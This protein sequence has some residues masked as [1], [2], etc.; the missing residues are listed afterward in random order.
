MNL[1]ELFP[2]AA[3]GWVEALELELAKSTIDTPAEIASFCAQLNQESAGL[4]RF[5]ENLMYTTPQRLCLV[6]PHRFGMPDKNGLVAPGLLNPY[7]YIRDP[8]G[9][10]NYVYADTNRAPPYALGNTDKGDGWKYRGMGP[11]QITGKSNYLLC[12][13]AIGFDLMKTPQLLKQPIPGIK[14]AFWFWSSHGLDKYD[15]DL[16]VRAETR[17]V[18]GGETGINERQAFYDNALRL[19]A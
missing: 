9:L 19:L 6:W 15:D 17:I 2:R 5:E 13:N 1:K 16:D 18:T 10:A 7:P 14:S 3:R 12:G 4:T 8:E 11:I